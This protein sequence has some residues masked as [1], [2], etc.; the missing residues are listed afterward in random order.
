MQSN[1]SSGLNE[2]F[3]PVELWLVVWNTR[4]HPGGKVALIVAMAGGAYCA[5]SGSMA[6]WSD[7]KSISIFVDVRVNMEQAL[8]YNNVLLLFSLWG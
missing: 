3:E 1:Y 7:T 8:K 6:E 5:L 2:L 4:N